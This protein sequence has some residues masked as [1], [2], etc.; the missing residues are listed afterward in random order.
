MG[1]LEVNLRN[2]ARYKEIARKLADPRGLSREQIDTLSREGMQNQQGLAAEGLAFEFSHRLCWPTKILTLVR[3]FDHV[4][5]DYHKMCDRINMLRATKKC[6][7]TP[8]DSPE[9]NEAG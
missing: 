4:C 1:I 3:R 5:L 8:L 6:S 2:K 7:Q 9:T